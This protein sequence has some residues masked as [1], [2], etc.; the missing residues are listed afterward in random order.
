MR[1]K[2]NAGRQGCILFALRELIT[3][4][5]ILL[6]VMLDVYLKA[7]LKCKKNILPIFCIKRPFCLLC[8]SVLILINLD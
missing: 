4:I 7:N 5:L 2:N 6:C 3:I 8:N 1:Y